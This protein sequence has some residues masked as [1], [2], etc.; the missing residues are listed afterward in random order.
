VDETGDVTRN[1][2]S[3]GL[4]L[5]DPSASQSTAPSPVR[6][7]TNRSVSIHNLISSPPLASPASDGGSSSAPRRRNS[8]TF[9]PTDE[10]ILPREL[11]PFPRDV[12]V[13]TE[14]RSNHPHS[15]MPLQDILIPS[16]KHPPVNTHT[17]NDQ[18]DED[19]AE[20]P[21]LHLSQTMWPL[22]ARDAKLL[23]HYITELGKWVFLSKSGLDIKMRKLIIGE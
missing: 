13:E 20:I 17:L 7:S 15:R 12:G 23:R 3:S 19:S 16:L 10:P 11:D 4:S 1:Y 21:S 2:D 8:I 6:I 22:P 14:R 9:S 5:L 18:M